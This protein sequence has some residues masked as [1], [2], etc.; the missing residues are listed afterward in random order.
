MSELFLGDSEDPVPSAGLP[1]VGGVEDTGDMTG[2][3]GELVNYEYKQCVIRQWYRTLWIYIVGVLAAMA[4]V[5]VLKRSCRFT[6]NFLGTIGWLRPFMDGMRVFVLIV[7]CCGKCAFDISS[8]LVSCLLQVGRLCGFLNAEDVPADDTQGGGDPGVASGGGNPGVASGGKQS[9]VS[10]SARSLGGGSMGAVG[11]GVSAASV[12]SGGSTG[13]L[14]DAGGAA[15]VENVPM[16]Q[17]GSSLDRLTLGASEL[18]ARANMP[19]AGVNMLAGPSG[20]AA[21]AAVR[22]GVIGSPVQSGGSISPRL[23]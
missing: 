11:G 17:L 12:G 1:D 5:W 16:Q 15:G 23:V 8:C 9:G 19:A 22:G 21:V 18:A 14:G 3:G 6:W 20:A 10:G 2:T 4:C 7:T 13:V